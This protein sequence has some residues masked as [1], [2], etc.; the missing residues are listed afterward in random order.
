MPLKNLV[1][2]IMKLNSSITEF[3]LDI[4][5]TQMSPAVPS[6]ISMLSFCQKNFFSSLFDQQQKQRGKEGEKVCTPIPW[7]T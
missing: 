6:F 2:I 1:A 5:K 3:P 4:L 7:T